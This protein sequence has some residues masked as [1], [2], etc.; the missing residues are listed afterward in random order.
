[1][2][3]L[4]FSA[5]PTPANWARDVNEFAGPGKQVAL[6]SFSEPPTFK[7]DTVDKTVRSEMQRQ[8]NANRLSLPLLIMIWGSVHSLFSGW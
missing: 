8:A 6:G 5:L 3:V 4:R 2:N 7:D 1:M